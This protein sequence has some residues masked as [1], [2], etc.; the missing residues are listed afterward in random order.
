MSTKG[1]GELR[2]RFCFRWQRSEYQHADEE[3]FMESAPGTEGQECSNPQCRQWIPADYN[4]IRWCA[5][6]APPGG[7]A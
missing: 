6:K 5:D 3:S 1:Y 2:C 4:N 7:S